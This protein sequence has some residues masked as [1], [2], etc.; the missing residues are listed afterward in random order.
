MR[1][2]DHKRINRENFYIKF[3]LIFDDF[4]EVLLYNN[5]I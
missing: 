2:K 4:S 5:Y 3:N 1:K